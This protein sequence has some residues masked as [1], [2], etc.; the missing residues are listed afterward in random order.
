MSAQ[1]DSAFLRMFL[2]ILGALVIFTVIILIV[3]NTITDAADEARGD[4][5]R[6]RAVIAERIQP[7]GRVNVVG[8]PAEP[9]APVA[10]ATV[11]KSGADIAAVACN[12]CHVAGVLG[13]PKNGDTAAWEQ[14]MAAAGGV[15]GLT[16]SVIA[17][18]GGMPPR[19]GST[20]SDAELRAAVEYLLT[21]AG[22]DVAAAPAAA[23]EP[24]AAPSPVATVGAAVQQAAEGM[25]DAA[26]SMADA[27]M[28][29]P[30]PAAPAAASA[31]TAIDLDKGKTIYDTACFACHVSGVAGAPKLEDKANW[32]PRIALGMDA[33][34][35]SV[36]N[37]KGA[38]PP[39]GGRMDIPDAD[40]KAAVAYMLHRVQ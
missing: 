17:G 23:P 4:D 8:A 18:K 28:P 38:M 25:A 16:A 13:A 21:D 2:I 14:R 6:Q 39:K 32:A 5:P 33:L 20:A 19:G 7:V 24:A 1:N 36:L 40:I 27:V 9:A 10:A 3:A 29:A 11:V 22:I 31:G 15:D 37:G 35:A 12:A 30:E 26:Q 34:V